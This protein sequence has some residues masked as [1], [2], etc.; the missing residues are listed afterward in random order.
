M[1]SLP[2]SCTILL[3]LALKSNTL[4]TILSQLGGLMGN[5]TCMAIGFVKWIA[6]DRQN[7]NI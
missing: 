4:V 5:K 2:S 6:V 7:P 1:D 3:C